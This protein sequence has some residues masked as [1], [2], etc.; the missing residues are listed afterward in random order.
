MLYLRMVKLVG[1]ALT[2]PPDV[3]SHLLLNSS[4]TA[5]TNIFR[6]CNN[7]FKSFFNSFLI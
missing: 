4:L 3:N 6:F 1:N 7:Y 5:T 2:T